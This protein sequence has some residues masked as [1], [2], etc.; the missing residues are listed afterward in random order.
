MLRGLYIDVIKSLKRRSINTNESILPK[1]ARKFGCP[2]VGCAFEHRLGTQP[3]CGTQRLLAFLSRASWHACHVNLINFGLLALSS[4][5]IVNKELN[6]P[7]Q[8]MAPTLM[9]S[10]C[11]L[12]SGMLACSLEEFHTHGRTY[13]LTSWL[14]SEQKTSLQSHQCQAHKF[15]KWWKNW[16]EPSEKIRDEDQGVWGD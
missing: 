5:I 16:N 2:E 4:S 7:L 13:I 9:P 10:K 11:P 8:G 3:D 6:K 15:I 14:L 1:Y 12:T